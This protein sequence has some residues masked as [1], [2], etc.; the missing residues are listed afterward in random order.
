MGQYVRVLPRDLFNEADLLKCYGRLWILL[1]ETSGHSAR[2]EEED[3]SEFDI[4]QDEGSGALTVRNLTFTV[5][6]IK[7]SISRPLNARS[8]WPL[9]LGCDDDPD[10]DEIRIF[11]ESGS[12]SSEMTSYIS[13]DRP[14]H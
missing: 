1:D 3:V 13:E 2:F 8:P 7:H 12:L 5:R 4:V 6:G 14:I 10:F 9:W 11:D